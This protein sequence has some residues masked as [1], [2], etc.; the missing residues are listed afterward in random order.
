MRETLG[1][2]RLVTKT[3]VIDAA[4]QLAVTRREIRK[5]EGGLGVAR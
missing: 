4:I 5:L 2:K 3:Q 1:R